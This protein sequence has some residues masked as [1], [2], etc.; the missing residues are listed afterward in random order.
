LEWS[1]SIQPGEW[2]VVVREANL[3]ANGAGVAI[4]LLEA[5]VSNGGNISLVMALGGYV[6]LSTAWADIEQ[7]E[8][9]AGADADGASMIQD[10]V[11][12]E[13][14]FE[15]MTWMLPLPSSGELTK[16]LFPEGTIAFDSEFTTVQHE[17]QLEMEY[18]GG[19]TTSV[20][21]DSTIAATLNYNRRVNSNLDVTFDE[22]SVGSDATVLDVEDVELE[23]MVSS[24]NESV[25]NTIT[26]D[27]TVNYNGT[28]I[29]D[30]FTVSGE[31]GLAQDSEDWTVQ[32]WNS[33]SNSYEDSVEIALGIGD[34]E[35]D[36]AL[37]ATVTVQVTLPDVA[38]AWSLENGHRVTVR[39][40]TDL[41][42]ATQ[43]S[44]KIFVPQTY[45]FS[46]SDA[47]D[48]LGMSALVE[49]R[50]S[51]D[52]TND[53][54]GQDTFTIELLESG[55]LEGWSITPMTSTLTLSK[56]ETRTQQFTVFAPESF[57]EGSFDLTV[58]V[59]S[60]D[61]AVAQQTVVV[62]VQAAVIKLEVKEANIVLKSDDIANQPGSVRVPVTNNGFLDAPSVLVYL[63]P[64][65]P[66]SQAERS[67]TISVPAGETV[68]AVFDDMTFI[69]GNQR[70]NIRIEVAGAETSSVDSISLPFGDT[71]SLEYYSQTESEG[72]SIWMT[73]LIVVLG[74]L[75][76]VGGVKTARSSRGGKF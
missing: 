4:G 44:A 60:L 46:I 56:G 71:F 23:A 22:A 53:G 9:H 74:V 62:N 33:S 29:V 39:M 64:T 55:V 49:R 41:G 6:E 48:E 75:V 19:Q 65:S 7:N 72:E 43:T 3:G 25:F 28:E 51:F 13:V 40:E 69:Q 11:E 5:T 36:A 8:H 54:N 50:F 70:F 59:N 32:I 27:Y 18:F 63:E 17:R 26:F 58:Y 12:L 24:G 16:L 73:L 67:V 57:T 37:A 31:L 34:N 14:T 20:A 30:V 68:E 61:E 35:T 1:A 47:T 42:E 21:A 2:V 66:A 38:D 15:D 45:A 76:V 52:I 10:V